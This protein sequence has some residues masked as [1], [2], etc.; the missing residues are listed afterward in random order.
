MLS[1]YQLVYFVPV[2]IALVIAGALV[3][4]KVTG[5]ARTLLWSG[6]ALVVVGQLVTL[7]TPLLVRMRATGS[8]LGTVSLTSLAMQ[9]T[10]MVLL[11]V[12]VGRAARLDSRPANPGPPGF[13]YPPQRGGW[14]AGPHHPSPPGQPS[15]ADQPHGPVQGGQ[16]TGLGQPFGPGQTF[17]PG[18]PYEP[19]QPTGSGP[20]RGAHEQASGA[21]FDDGHP[22]YAPPDG[23][24]QADTGSP[25]S[26]RP[27]TYGRPESGWPP[28]D[29]PGH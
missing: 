20:A 28:S 8:L 5:A 21:T 12:A 14:T 4:G 11:I 13:T 22:G 10:G 29:Q 2:A 3:T 23:Y 15:G 6:I 9:T 24:Q 7:L 1:L 27:G 19:G 18:W 17:G 16:Q 26:G 25:G